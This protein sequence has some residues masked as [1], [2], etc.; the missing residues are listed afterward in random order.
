MSSNIRVQK[1]C[2]HCNK[3]FEAKTTVTKFC[4]NA[5]S[6]KAYKAKKRNEKIAQRGA[7]FDMIE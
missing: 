2:K 1:I 5:C 6:K 7:S 3:L 4:S